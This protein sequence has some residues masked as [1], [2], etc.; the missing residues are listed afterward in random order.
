MNDDRMDKS[1]NEDP[2]PAPA[3]DTTGLSARERLNGTE[4]TSFANENA[5]LGTALRTIYQEAVE[6][7]IPPEMLDLLNRLN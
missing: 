6:E 2:A 7:S 1:A 3:P 4:L 5:N